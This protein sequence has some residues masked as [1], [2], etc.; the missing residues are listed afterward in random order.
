MSDM[1]YPQMNNR[2]VP[3]TFRYTQS[4]PR[5]CCEGVL[6]NAKYLIVESELLLKRGHLVRAYFFA[7]A[8]IAEIGR[9]YLASDAQGR[10]LTGST[11][12]AKI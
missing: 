6:G 11:V 4:T 5:D 2:Q 10:N 3:N 8:S 1:L 7:A 9:T 12:T